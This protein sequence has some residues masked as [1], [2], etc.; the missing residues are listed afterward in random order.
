MFS[1]HPYTL[2]FSPLSLFHSGSHVML[3][4][5]TC[6]FDVCEFVCV[7]T[8]VCNEADWCECYIVTMWGVHAEILRRRRST[9]RTR[10]NPRS[11]VDGRRPIPLSRMVSSMTF[12]ATNIRFHH[13]VYFIINLMNIFDTHLA[14]PL[15]KKEQRMLTYFYTF[16]LVL[17]RS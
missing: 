16:R 2:I 3:P 14:P 1:S 8:D 13:I 5:Y 15:P 10:R 11:S 9:A 17:F 4:M 6:T 7:S 12:L